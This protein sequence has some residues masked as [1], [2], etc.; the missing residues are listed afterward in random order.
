MLR[1]GL[2]WILSATAAQSWTALIKIE[3]IMRW[4]RVSPSVAY[5]ILGDFITHTSPTIVRLAAAP[6]VCYNCIP[7]YTGTPHDFASSP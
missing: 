3:S 5:P 1:A 7:A 2:D 4:S 6:H